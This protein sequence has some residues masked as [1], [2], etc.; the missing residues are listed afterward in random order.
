MTK[1]APAAMETRAISQNGGFKIRHTCV[2]IPGL[3]SCVLVKMFFK[4]V[5]ILFMLKND[6]IAIIS[7]Q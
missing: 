7:L 4:T 5:L 6:T 3:L 1:S 2:Q